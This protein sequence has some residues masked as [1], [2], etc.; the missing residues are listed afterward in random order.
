MSS[1]KKLLFIA[2]VLVC[3]YIGAYLLYANQR[4][5]GAEALA[6]AI[7][8]T[9]FAA[10]A[11][12][13][14]DDQFTG[15]DVS[16]NRIPR[17][18]GLV[19][20][21]Y[22]IP[23]LYLYVFDEATPHRYI[24]QVAA[25]TVLGY[26]G[27]RIGM[28]LFEPRRPIPFT[29]R[30]TVRQQT[31]LMLLCWVAFLALM[32]GY[33]LRIET[34]TYFTHAIESDYV[35]SPVESMISA[36]VQPFEA[37][38]MLLPLLLDDTRGRRW[39][40]W[41]T[42]GILLVLHMTAGE[43]RL[44][45]TDIIILVAALQVIRGLKITWPKV[46]VSCGLLAAGLALIQVTRLVSLAQGVTGQ[47]G[48]G[49][50]MGL[51]V[52]AVT[53]PAETSQM[54]SEAQTNS[55]SRADLLPAFLAKIIDK[56]EAGYPYDYGNIMLQTMSGLIPHVL[57]PDKPPVDSLQ[58][59]LMHKYDLPGIDDSPG[60][61]SSYYAFG[62]PI[63][64]FVWLFAFGAALQWLANRTMRKNTVGLWILFTWVLCSVLFTEQDLEGGLL[65]NLRHCLVAF[66]IYQAIYFFV[67]STSDASAAQS[68]KY[69]PSEISL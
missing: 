58:L 31:A 26:L 60:I 55:A 2:L 45:L 54:L 63:A 6:L 25:Y 52:T 38:L 69:L 47:N 43:F 15:I 53:H 65:T 64:V 51:V 36:F 21:L 41:M 50:S 35:M 17:L 40:R 32:A 39:F 46:F 16:M 59:L 13:L 61:L 44:V 48:I 8:G 42:Y 67:P 68:N 20:T 23:S 19:F 66:C 9:L 57:W 33:V 62:G 22:Y 29:A 10:L 28:A 30:F 7:C 3:A 37:P 11:P 49:Y 14:I 24:L 4:L 56:T 18:F 1:L 34:G 27:W 12:E 5:D